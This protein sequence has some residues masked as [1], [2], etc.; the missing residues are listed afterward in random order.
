VCSALLGCCEARR[1]EW[2]ESRP[3]L[4]KQRHLLRSA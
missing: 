3:E 1:E 2:R 4:A